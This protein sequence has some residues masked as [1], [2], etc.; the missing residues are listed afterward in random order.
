MSLNADLVN[1]RRVTPEQLRAGAQA[2]IDKGGA[3][4]NRL[5]MEQTRFGI[6]EKG[7]REQSPIFVSG[8]DVAREHERVNSVYIVDSRLGFA[9]KT[10]RFWINHLPGGGEDKQKWKTIGH[11]HTVEAV[12][13]Y[14][15]GYGYSVID[16]KRYDWE[17][18]DFICVPQFAWHRHVNLSDE[19]AAYAASTTGPLS[20]SIGQALYEDER[21]PELWVFAQQGDDA[22]GSLIPGAVEEPPELAEYDSRAAELYREELGFAR[23][24]EAHRRK[25]RVLVKAGD[26]KFE[27]TP[28]GRVAYVVDGRVGFHTKALST[29]IGEVDPEKHSGAHR[30][31]Y[32][33]IDY[34]LTGSGQAVVDDVTFDVKMG[35][36]L[37]IP[38]YAW[39]QYFNTGV[40][41][42][43]V[44]AFST[45]PMLEGLGLS[46]VQQ[47]E[48]ANF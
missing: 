28:M 5:G 27:R 42:L 20:M 3:Q 22:M 47:G 36:T 43:R 38:P 10:H 12:I 26:L 48:L 1:Q 23:V 9:N 2:I 8:D 21:Y 24:E 30:H 44:L 19:R 13:Y 33:E 46:L 29:V 7:R 41:P 32:D 17:A 35:D 25:S 39:H 18:G 34:V 6:E 45:R 11:R 37:A 16:G 15:Q 40:E 4:K 31:L 14:L